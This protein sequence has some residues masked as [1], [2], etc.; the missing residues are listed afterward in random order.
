M[1]LGLALAALIEEI[2][3]LVHIYCLMLV[4]HI[5]QRIP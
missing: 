2:L 4:G 5:A 3:S 1:K